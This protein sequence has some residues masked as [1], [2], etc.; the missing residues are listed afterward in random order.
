MTRTKRILGT[1]AI[2]C[3]MVALPACGAGQQKTK[4]DIMQVSLGYLNF[5]STNKKPPASEKEFSA[6]ANPEEVAAL[7]KLQSQGYKVYW[8]VDPG[9]TSGGA[10]NT[11][12]I[13]PGDAATKGGMVGMA[14]GTV[15]TMTADEFNKAAKPK[16]K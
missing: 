13:Y 8:G 10:G 15:K 16:V 5:V 12:L 6:K 9:K 7:G 3:L 11:V 1:V 14:D 4:N 2:G